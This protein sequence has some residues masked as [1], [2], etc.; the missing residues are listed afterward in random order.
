MTDIMKD[1]V[2]IVLDHAASLP[3]DAAF[4]PLFA[5]FPERDA[6]KKY[7][8]DLEAVTLDAQLADTPDAFRRCLLDGADPNVL[9]DASL[10]LGA[11][12]ALVSHPDFA[13]T[14]VQFRQVLER[15]SYADI[16]DAIESCGADPDHLSYALV[17]RPSAVGVLLEYG[18]VPTAGDLR[19][20]AYLGEWVEEF[21]M[22]GA[23]PTAE[24]LRLAIKNADLDSFEALVEHGC[25][26]DETCIEIAKDLALVDMIEKLEKL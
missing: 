24:A 22:L 21:L 8:R 23:T 26:V 4:K 25:P 2:G 15:G 11:F 7:F 17:H 9:V 1:L 16:V 13:L 5:A 12:D 14:V 18:A 10:R 19:T 6:A 20:A 3:F